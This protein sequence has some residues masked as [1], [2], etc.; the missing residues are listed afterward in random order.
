[1]LLAVCALAQGQGAKAQGETVKNLPAGQVRIYDYDTQAYQT[2][3]KVVKSD[4][5]WKKILTPEQY[6]VT[7]GH[8][9]ELAFCEL[10][11][12]TEGTGIYA[13]VNC[14]THLFLKDNKFE[15]GTGW[16]SFRQPIDEANVGFTQDMSYGMK[17]TEVHCRRCDAHLGHVFDDGPSPTYQR[18][19]INSV[20]LQFIPQKTLLLHKATFAGGCFWC[21]QPFF[22]RLKGV[23]STQ[24]GYTGS[25]EDNPTYEE[26]SSGLTGHV[27]AIEITYD[28]QGVSFEK[29]LD[30][31]WRNIDPTDDNGQFYDQG[32]QYR[33]VIFY[34]DEQ[35]RAAAEASKKT[36][37]DSGRFA[38][39]IATE[40]LPASAF[41]P[42]EEYHQKYYQKNSPRYQAYH[43]NS[44]RKEFEQKYWGKDA[45]K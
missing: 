20:A 32:A 12:K 42:A 15:S 7:R 11:S 30:I 1:M 2:V 39:P 9:T 3:D 22:D 8:G 44:G 4:A 19:C 5:E 35:Q 16:P 38:M 6:R 33:T 23:K 28:A 45:K 26:V 18:Y 41:Y 10:P 36:L 31:F 21:M 17:R 13:C 34:H 24:V 40:I 37:A 43:D 25:D 27:E 14:G 29:L